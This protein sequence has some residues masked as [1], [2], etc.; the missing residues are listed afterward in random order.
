MTTRKPVP[1]GDVP[2]TIMAAAL[3]AAV[4]NYYRDTRPFIA[5]RGPQSYPDAVRASK[6]YQRQ[7]RRR[8]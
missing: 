6:R 4:Q 2:E 5:A 3:V 7:Q 8:R 1:D